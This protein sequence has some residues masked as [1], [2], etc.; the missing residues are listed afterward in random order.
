VSLPPSF[1]SA[2]TTGLGLQS[3]GSDA[4]KIVVS[5]SG[6]GL[7]LTRLNPD[8]SPDGSFG[9]DGFYVESRMNY[10]VGLAIQPDDK[11]IMAGSPNNHV[12]PYE[13]VV[14]RV[15][16]DGS[17]YDPSFGSAGL[18]QTNFGTQP[19][20]W[21]GAEALA[22]DGKIV[23]VGGGTDF[24][25]V[26]FLGDPLATTTTLT[27]SLNPS[28]S[29]RSVTFTATVTASYSHDTPTGTASFY[30]G[31]TLLGSGTLSTAGGVTTASFTTASLAT[32]TH[33]ITATYGGDS[34][35]LSSTSAPLSQVVNTT[36]TASMSATTLSSSA[37]ATGPYR[38]AQGATPYSP[39]SIFAPLVLDDPVVPTGPQG[40]KHRRLS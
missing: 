32:G 40:G 28:T 36:A 37:L 10:E 15:L 39:G 22:P 27:S 7:A 11:L 21:D 31:S 19:E 12:D 26:R 8:G 25:T 24:T 4:G 33:S 20:A 1:P 23:V 18:G 29:G 16:A 9:S 17:S 30:D 2:G 14:T 3:T 6:N 5:M 13:F 38:P 35:D 34:N